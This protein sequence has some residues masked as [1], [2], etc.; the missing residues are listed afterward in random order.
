MG[1]RRPIPPAPPSPDT[2]WHERRERLDRSFRRFLL[3]LAALFPLLLGLGIWAESKLPDVWEIGRTPEG[4]ILYEFKVGGRRLV[5][6]V[7]WR[8]D[9]V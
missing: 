4:C 5:C 7:D 2:F 8:A 9:H 3:L 6:P 1:E